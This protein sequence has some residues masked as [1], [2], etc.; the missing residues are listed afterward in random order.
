MY[1]DILRLTNEGRCSRRVRFK[2][3]H[4]RET[5]FSHLLETIND[6]MSAIE[7]RMKTALS[8]PV[9]VMAYR[10]MIEPV[11]APRRSAP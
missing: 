4:M 2:K 11:P 8:G 7:E 5:A 1:G 6:A 9:I 10:I 3:I